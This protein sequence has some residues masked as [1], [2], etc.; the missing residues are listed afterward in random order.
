MV[1]DTNHYQKLREAAEQMNS[2]PDSMPMQL[3]GRVQTTLFPSYG[4]DYS[5]PTSTK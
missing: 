4:S 3:Q 5:S 1:P 2:V